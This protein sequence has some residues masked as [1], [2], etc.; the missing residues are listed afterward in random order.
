MR[1]G[2][3]PECSDV[4]KMFD[5]WY[6]LVQYVYRSSYLTVPLCREIATSAY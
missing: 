5:E 3:L 6:I 2:N 4:Q 1:R